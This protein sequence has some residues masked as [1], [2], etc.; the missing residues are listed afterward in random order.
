MSVHR[1]TPLPTSA[2]RGR[3]IVAASVLSATKSALQQFQGPDGRHEGLVYWVG[4]R[5][6]H[7]AF[8][9]SAIIP[10]SD[11]GPQHVFVAEGEV[12]KMSRRARA[13]GLAIVAQV[14]SHPG[15]DTRH[16][17]GD[18]KLILMPSEGMFSLVVARYGDGGLLP[19]EGSGLHQYQDKR[20]V[21]TSAL[22]P[23][24]LVVGPVIIQ[25]TP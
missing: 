13:L 2:A 16:S 5:C 22:S 24:A 17:D 12:G 11:H 8:V 4:R 21:L 20:W 23:D 1:L 7:D 9:L 3:L 25:A 10:A 15:N 18:D 19:R 6:E 14:H